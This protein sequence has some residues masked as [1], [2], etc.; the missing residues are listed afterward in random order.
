MPARGCHGTDHDLHL[1]QAGQPSTTCSGTAQPSPCTPELKPH[2][3]VF[4]TDCL[5]RVSH[6]R[7]GGRPT[8]EV[9]GTRL[10]GAEQAQLRPQHQDRK[11]H[12]IV[13][14]VDA[15]GQLKGTEL[16]TTR[17][18]CEDGTGGPDQAPTTGLHRRAPA[19]A[20]E[21]PPHTHAGAA[22][23]PKCQQ[24][25]LLRSSP[26]DAELQAPR[27]HCLCSQDRL[28]LAPSWIVT[29]IPET[30]AGQPH[31]VQ[32]PH[33]HPQPRPHSP[34]RRCCIT[35]LQ[36]GGPGGG[37]VFR[38]RQPAPSRNLV[39]VSCKADWV[40]RRLPPGQLA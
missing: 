33:S 3:P 36:H 11:Q 12:P 8:R 39:T 18:Q 6:A 27:S 29:E 30:T 10:P 7:R 1:Q 28:A 31:R 26:T 23:S 38:G 13:E 4:Q 14:E 35:A 17:L 21:Q 34:S 20:W 9:A 37:P 16:S 15:L 5:T 19:G 22:R 32:V 40:T 25:A 24:E 2:T